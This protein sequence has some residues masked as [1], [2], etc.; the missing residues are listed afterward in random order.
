MNVSLYLQVLAAKKILLRVSIYKKDV[1]K[2]CSTEHLSEHPLNYTI[3]EL[4]KQF[5]ELT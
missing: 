3:E 4:I 5:P 2:T 1:L